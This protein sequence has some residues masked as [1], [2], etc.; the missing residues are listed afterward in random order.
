[1]LSFETSFD[2]ISDI[3]RDIEDFGKFF[4]KN[5]VAPNKFLV[6]IWDYNFFL[7]IN[8]YAIGN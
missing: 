8:L 2:E 6:K 4:D 3:P 5:L 7:L 1:M